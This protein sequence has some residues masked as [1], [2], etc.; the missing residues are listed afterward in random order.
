MGF[1]LFACNCLTETTHIACLSLF[2]RALIHTVN[3]KSVIQSSPKL[4]AFS[5][6]QIPGENLLY[7]PG[8]WWEEEKT[9]LHLNS[10][11]SEGVGLHRADFW[12]CQLFIKLFS[13]AV[14]LK[15]LHWYII[16]N[17]IAGIFLICLISQHNWDCIRLIGSHLSNSTDIISADANIKEWSHFPWTLLALSLNHFSPPEF[18]ERCPRPLPF[19]LLWCTE[20]HQISS[21]IWPGCQSFFNY[22]SWCKYLMNRTL[23]ETVITPSTD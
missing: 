21:N 19:P 10:L 6:L 16:V 14:T 7:K 4:R 17:L 8:G 13:A 5:S 18:E 3:L 15:V 2:P 20:I 12:Q 9:N 1:G 11:L 23:D 22:R